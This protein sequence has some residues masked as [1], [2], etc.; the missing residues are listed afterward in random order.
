MHAGMCIQ[1]L[2]TVRL[3]CVLTGTVVDGV[4]IFQ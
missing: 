1:S 3:I 2:N 4:T